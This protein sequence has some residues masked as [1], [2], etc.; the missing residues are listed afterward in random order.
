MKSFINDFCNALSCKKGKT[1]NE[2]K[3]FDDFNKIQEVF[4]TMKC[5]NCSEYSLKLIYRLFINIKDEPF[6]NAYCDHCGL[7]HTYRYANLI[8]LHKINDD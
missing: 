5:I 3:I 6:I 4:S 7:T 8:K 2:D 1:M